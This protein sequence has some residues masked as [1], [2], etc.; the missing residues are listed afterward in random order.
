[1]HERQQILLFFLAL[2]KPRRQS[3]GRSYGSLGGDLP[4][5]R[6]ISM[7]SVLSIVFCAS[8]GAEFMTRPC[9]VWLV[10]GERRQQSCL[11]SP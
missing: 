6:V 5:V 1:M 11:F 3:F 9:E 4:V 10:A 8:D 2:L 7:S